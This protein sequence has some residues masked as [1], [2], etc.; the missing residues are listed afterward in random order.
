MKV[1][2]DTCAFLW[3]AAGDSALSRRARDAFSDPDN[4]VYLSA[5]SAWEIAIKNLLGKLPLPRAAAVFVPEERARHEIQPLP[6]GEDAALASS[7]LPD[8]HRDPFDR[9]LVAQAIM[10]GLTL[11]T[12]DPLIAQYPVPTF[13]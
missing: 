9:M 1:L 2:L 3:I 8:L 11:L 6:I 13:W 12:P 4:D 7:R 10:G 5:A